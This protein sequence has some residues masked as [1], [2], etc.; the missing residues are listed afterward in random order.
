[1]NFL[2][3]DAIGEKAKKYVTIGGHD[4]EVIEMTVERMVNAMKRAKQ[5][6]KLDPDSPEHFE[7]TIVFIHDAIPSLS[8]ERIRALKL[9]QVQALSNFIT[10]EVEDEVERGEK[11]AGDEALGK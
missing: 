9:S 11:V 7:E 3:L 2:N 4:H 10:A 8:P 6:E 1:M 5:L